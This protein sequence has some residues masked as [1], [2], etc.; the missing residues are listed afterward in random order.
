MPNASNVCYTLTK[1]PPP[2]SHTL[3][4]LKPMEIIVE[5]IVKRLISDEMV[6]NKQDAFVKGRSLETKLHKV[7][8][9]EYRIASKDYTFRV[10]IY[11]ERDFKNVKT[12]TRVQSLDQFDMDHELIN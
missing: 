6:K 7:L 3:F 11:I 1:A 10:L 12:G 2:I 5:D 9:N 8:R 4:L